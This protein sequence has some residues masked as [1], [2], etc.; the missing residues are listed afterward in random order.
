MK[1]IGLPPYKIPTGAPQDERNTYDMLPPPIPVQS[2][3][4]RPKTLEPWGRVDPRVTARKRA[5]D[6][7]DELLA[8]MGGSYD[9]GRGAM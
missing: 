8:M 3:E 1:S 5:E 9:G 7:L 4:V 6:E 2:L